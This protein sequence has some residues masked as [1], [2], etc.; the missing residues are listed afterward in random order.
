MN[1]KT[2]D[3]AFLFKTHDKDS[4]LNLENILRIEASDSLCQTR[5]FYF[6]IMDI[7][8]LTSI[9]QIKKKF[10]VLLL[11]KFC[12]IRQKEN[13]I[14]FFDKAELFLQ[15]RLKPNLLVQQFD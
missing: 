14:N 2:I 4:L 11:M 6:L 13:R 10:T 8:S 7:K 1:N 12:T 5:D 3:E 9:Y 15:T